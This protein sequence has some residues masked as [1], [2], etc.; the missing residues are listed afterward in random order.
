M[1]KLHPK[2]CHLSL[3]SKKRS[4]KSI[5]TLSINP[6]S[7]EKLK[8]NQTLLNVLIKP[9]KSNYISPYEQVVDVKRQSIDRPLSVSKLIK[10]AA[11]R[12]NSS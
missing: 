11:F 4:Q 8:T 1:K 10:K 7:V 2:S 12:N 3:S 9:N 6:K 5:T